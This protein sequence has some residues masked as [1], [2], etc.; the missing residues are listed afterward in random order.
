MIMEKKERAKR[1]KKEAEDDKINRVGN[2]PLRP[3]V[4]LNTR[5]SY[6]RIT[7]RNIFFF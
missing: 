2:I 6:R 4:K 3:S 5:K 7:A 1:K